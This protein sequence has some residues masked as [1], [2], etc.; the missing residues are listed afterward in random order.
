MYNSTDLVDVGKAISLILGILHFGTDPD[1]S[2]F[3]MEQE[4]EVDDE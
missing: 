1:G 2:A 3:P 4:F